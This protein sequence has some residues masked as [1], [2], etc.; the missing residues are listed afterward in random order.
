MVYL[1]IPE[2]HRT[3]AIRQRVPLQKL[4]ES[5]KRKSLSQEWC[6]NSQR[7]ST[8][9]THDD[10]RCASAAKE[11]TLPQK[12]TRG[13]APLFRHRWSDGSCNCNQLFIR[14]NP[15]GAY[16]T[17]TIVQT[18]N[19]CNRNPGAA[20]VLLFHAFTNI[21]DPLSFKKVL[22]IRRWRCDRMCMPKNVFISGW[23]LPHSIS[24]TL[25]RSFRI[26]DRIIF[27]HGIHLI[28]IDVRKWEGFGR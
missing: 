25:C 19:L 6:H 28:H 26:L 13:Y 1:A 18:N 23:W 14:Y 12:T 7:C 11:S 21:Q 27:F 4:I 15:I 16:S 3:L 22:G 5:R 2:I 9:R 17:Q 10:Q 8:Q 24:S 20:S